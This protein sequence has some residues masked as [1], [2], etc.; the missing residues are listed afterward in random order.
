MG[1]YLMF[2][3]SFDG[4]K[5]WNDLYRTPTSK[6]ERRLFEGVTYY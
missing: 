2:P 1:D 6:K 3:E 4:N 5:E